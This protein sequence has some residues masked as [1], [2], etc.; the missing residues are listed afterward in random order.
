M[1]VD[2][3]DRDRA[4]TIKRLLLYAYDHLREGIDRAEL[5]HDYVCK[6]YGQL[7]DQENEELETISFLK[8]AEI[9]RRLIQRDDRWK[10]VGR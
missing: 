9:V 7:A 1:P 5:A 3:R 10:S 2:R 6:A 8:V 4:V